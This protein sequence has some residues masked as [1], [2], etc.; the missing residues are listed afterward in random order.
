MLMPWFKRLTVLII[1]LW[2]ISPFLQSKNPNQINLDAFGQLPILHEG[3]VKPIDSLARN[4]LLIISGKQYI[5]HESKK[6]GPIEWF[7]NV[8]TNSASTNTY[9]QFLVQN[10]ILFAHSGPEFQKAKYRTNY[11]YLEK[12]GPSFENQVKIANAVNAQARTPIQREILLINKRLTRYVQLK[13]TLKPEDA[14]DF[15]SEVTNY[16]HIIPL[17]LAELSKHTQSPDTMPLPL[18]QLN[19]YFKRYQAMNEFSGFYPIPNLDNRGIVEW[20]SIGNSLLSKLDTK[21][22]DNPALTL[23]AYQVKDVSKFNQ[24]TTD[25]LTLL[26]SQYPKL[27]RYMKWE[28]NLN[29][30]DLFYKC[31]ILYLI[32]FLLLLLSWANGSKKLFSIIMVLLLT[33]FALNTGTLLLRMIIQGRPPV[34]NLYS[35]AIFVGWI[36][37]G[38]G[39]LFERF[40]AYGFGAF[41]ASTVGAATLVIAHHLAL[42]GDTMEMMQAVLDSNFWL[43]THVVTVV[44]GYSTMF[45]A[46]AFAHIYI[47]G[48]FL[49]PKFNKDLANTLGRLCYAALCIGMLFSFVGTV[50]GGIWADQ[51]WGRFW[52]WDPKE[53]GAILIVLWIAIILHLRLAGRI[54]YRGMMVLAILGNIVCSFSWFG[55]NLLGIG[56]HSYGFMQ[57]GFFWLISFWVV[58]IA[59]AIIGLMP[60]RLWRGQLR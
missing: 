59:I 19:Q 22:P 16:K 18:A 36:A 48:G 45:I 4:S 57:R 60:I 58:Q 34:T 20:N 41:T 43:S 24:L 33:T 9:E 46:G 31:I 42:Q 15:K 50:L 55:V 21:V 53:N 44:I 32:A 5:R 8:S 1:L 47:L 27:M 2:A 26:K 25:Y 3:R 10:P 35:S 56:L 52:G 13:N 29:K 51:S 28:A 30:A 17:G 37:V 6:I 40:N 38:L 14:S 23:S 54:K 11:I 49:F 12:N 39:L 7:L